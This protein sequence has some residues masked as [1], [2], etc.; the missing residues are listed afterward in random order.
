[1]QTLHETEDATLPDERSS[2]GRAV[3]RARRGGVMR[4]AGPVVGLLLLAMYVTFLA[5]NDI[6]DMMGRGAL[7]A[8]PG[9]WRSIA[10]VLGLAVFAVVVARA[11]QDGWRG[12][13][14][15][16]WAISHPATL[17]LGGITLGALFLRVFGIS[18]NL[19][20][21]SYPDE[22]AVADRA[23]GILQTGD[24]NPHYFVYPNLYT[25]M[26]A[27]VYAVRFFYLVSAGQLSNLDSIT[28]T[29]FYLWGRLL[30][31]LLGALTVP[32]VYLAARRL[33]GVTVG[34][35]TS[36]FM[37]TNSVHLVHS[38]L[39]TTDVPATF[40]SALSLLAIVRLLPP[41]EDLKAN[42]GQARLAPVSG[43]VAAG[44]AM[45][46]AVGTKY[47][48][49]LV[50]L[51]FLVAHAYAVADVPEERVRR[52]LGVR[53]WAGLGAV[54]ATFLL[55]TPFIIFD[56]PSFLNEVASV[57]THYRF[58]HLG[59]EGDDNWRFYT[60]I[61]LRTD[62]WPTLLTL[63]GIVVAFVRHRRADVLLLIFPLAF[64]LSMSSYRVNFTRNLL[65]ML[66]FT[67][68][69]A[70]VPLAFAGKA[71]LARILASRRINPRLAGR[72]APWL[73]ALLVAL[74]VLPMTASAL[75]RGYRQTQPDTRVR[76]SQW[77]DA[78]VRPGTKLWLEPQ[79]PVLTPGRYLT[80]HSEH[81]TD[82]PPDWY[83]ANRYEYVVLSEG[84]YKD[85]VYDHPEA[86]PPLRDAYLRFFADNES[87]LAASFESNKIDHPG[88]SIRIYRTA[89]TPPRS[90]ADVHAQYPLGASFREVSANG[91]TI[92]L[93]GLDYPQAV[94]A[95]S[96]LPLT[97]YWASDRTLSES[98][99]IFVH[100]FD[101][102]GTT[103]AQRDTAPRNG[104]FPTSQW[105]ANEVVVDEA[106]LSLSDGLPPGSYMLRV[107]LYLQKDG[108]VQRA[109]TLAGGPPGSGPDYIVLGPVM[110]QAPE[111]K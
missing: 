3:S 29:D 67:S 85:V 39:I 108:H 26:Q 75:Q 56:L 65:P 57:I 98:Y 84:A 91:G 80:G 25:Y 19:P 95:G 74:S 22:P 20:Y 83:V 77:L 90:T 63:V 87:R 48:S 100:L 76:A 51:P 78:N 13:R 14:L 11:W 92:R 37:A 69:L 109:F 73:L 103:L 17:A 1:M 5:R 110:V 36:A 96:A 10:A 55:T 89:Y 50:L 30:T 16:A 38:Q 107:G 70:A 44:V 32:L 101:Q 81:V 40:F 61:F 18:D 99:T 71:L 43:Y 7:P 45:G 46:L 15:R 72:I 111:Q 105:V 4:W 58:G 23:L 42:D 31:A 53:L 49:A 24:Y 41:G 27:A 59:F 106:D 64:Y 79:T 88:P 54:A 60:E 33:Y 93:L 52:F 12:T 86:N 9:G 28:P 2:V 8:I 6:D 102:A 34:L 35:I 47:N 66:P 104:T 94:E 68:I 97:L 62:T 21:T 82:N